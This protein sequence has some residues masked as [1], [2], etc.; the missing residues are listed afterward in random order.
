MTDIDELRWLVPQAAQRRIVNDLKQRY[1]ALELDFEVVQSAAM[2][3][4][5]YKVK[6]ALLTLEVL[7][8]KFD[9][10]QATQTRSL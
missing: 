5:S 2:A 10:S 9:R 1:P 7:P 3:M 8:A 6:G 4:E